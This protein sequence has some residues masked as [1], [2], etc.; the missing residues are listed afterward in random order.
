MTT[1]YILIDLENVQPRNINILLK[2]TFKIYVFV[3]ENQTKI[4][5]ELAETMQKFGDNA[6]YIKISGNGKNALDFHIAF[7]LGKL[8]VT[9]DKAC[10]HIISKD[11]GF[12]PLVNNLKKNN[13]KI[14]RHNNIGEIPLLKI[15]NTDN[16][17]EKVNALIKNLIGRGQSKPRKISTLS[18][19]INSLFSKKLSQEEMT[20]LIQILK[21]KKYIRVEQEKVSYTLPKKISSSLIKTATQV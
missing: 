13:V 5:F 6:K 19:T 9:D 21:S 12:D 14:F 17:D 10:F 20:S 4:P 7:Y 1:N 15:S 3:G 8:S 11:T 18:N 2:N 16:I